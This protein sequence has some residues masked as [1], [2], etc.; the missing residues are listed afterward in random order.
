MEDLNSNLDNNV[1]KI[2]LPEVVKQTKIETVENLSETI[3]QVDIKIEGQ[4]RTIHHTTSEVERLR[5]LL[6]LPKKEID[7]PSIEFNKQKINTLN[8][9]KALLKSKLEELLLFN[10]SHEHIDVLTEAAENKMNWINS[11]E[12]E[13]RLKETGASD[14]KIVEMKEKLLNNLENGKPIILPEDKFREMKEILSEVSGQDI[15][16]GTGFHIDNDDVV[17]ETMRNSIVFPEHKPIPKPPLPGVP[18]TSI[19]PETKTSISNQTLHHELGHLTQDGLLHSDL[20]K[21][22]KL[23]TREGSPD[24]KYVGN[25]LET[26]TRIQ[27][28]FRDLKGLFDPHQEKFQE[29]HVELLK[30]KLKFNELSQDTKDLLAHYDDEKLIEI[31][32]TL[33][34]I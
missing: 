5:T 17:P 7:I 34:A 12:L 14:E 3:N 33:P 1:E 18:F 28:V 30:E 10:K 24:P 6:R 22:T 9:E 29:R 15:T 23:E 2:I 19:V 21:S 32:N 27:S 26:D 31:I 11:G 8:N 25:I 4:K 20:Y 16:I 13:R